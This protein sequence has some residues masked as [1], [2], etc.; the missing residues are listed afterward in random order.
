MALIKST[1]AS[2]RR[3]RMSMSSIRSRLNPWPRGTRRQ[4][5]T[6]REVQ[7]LPVRRRSGRTERKRADR[8]RAGNN[9]R[10]LP[11]S[12]G[13]PAMPWT[14]V[15]NSYIHFR[16]PGYFPRL[17]GWP[18]RGDQVHQTKRP[19]KPNLR[20]TSLLNLDLGNQPGSKHAS[21]DRF[22][23]CA[24]HIGAKIEHAVFIHTFAASQR[25]R[26]RARC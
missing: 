12:L 20:K 22:H 8:E 7:Q 5:P 3:R 6:S 1:F 26:K 9:S 19:G 17:S 13:D 15:A 10:C 14:S 2:R 11:A 16:S 25:I 23:K 24:E 18:A 21:P 4:R